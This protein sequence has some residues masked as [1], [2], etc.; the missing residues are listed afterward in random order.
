MTER[1]YREAE[2]VNKSTLWNLQKS[3][4]HYKFF[5]ENPAED[6]AAFQFGRAVHAAVLQPK[7]YKRDFAVIPEGIDRRTKAGK[8]AYE[9]FLREAEGR[10][11]ISAEDAEKVKRIASAIRKNPEAMKLLKGT[12]RERALFWTDDNGVLCKCRIDAFRP[13]APGE[14]G[15]IIDLKTAADAG[16]DTFSR[17]ALRYGYDVQCAHYIDGYQHKI[18]AVPPVWYFIVIEK[19]EPYA[20][21]ILRADIGFVDYGI[22]RRQQL[23]ER[24]KDC[25]ERGSYPGY[26]TNE[27]I[28]PYWAEG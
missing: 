9:A 12:R 23:I 16:T 22:T 13:G 11:I 25:R 18:S 3:P 26:G 28:L 8:E 6:K 24:L 10:E 14:P 4:A 5:L 17:E 20:I 1:E 21:N 27:L 2:G 7:A 15:L 19:T